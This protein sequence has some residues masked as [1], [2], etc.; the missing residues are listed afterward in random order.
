MI[1]LIVILF[2]GRYLN[3]FLKKPDLN[4]LTL[5]VKYLEHLISKNPQFE[6]FETLIYDYTILGKPLEALKLLKQLEK[7]YPTKVDSVDYLLFKY[8]ILMNIYFSVKENSLKKQIKN[9]IKQILF[10]LLTK[11]GNSKKI[12]SFVYFQSIEFGFIDIAYQAAYKLAILTKS[13]VW[14]KKAILLAINVKYVPKQNIITLINLVNL[15]EFDLKT[16]EK[17]IK[18]FFYVK[19][20]YKESYKFLQIYLK[21]SNFLPEDLQTIYLYLAVYNNKILDI[22]EIIEETLKKK[23]KKMLIKLA[24]QYALAMKKLDLAKKLIDE[25]ALAFP[26]DYAYIT[27][28]IKSALATGDPFFARKISLKIMRGLKNE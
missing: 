11:A 7:K 16:L 28:I 25:Y 27:F 13:P 20:N 15:Q 12:L 24:I 8:K 10:T 21:K 18:F 23:D 3:S 2:P 6:Y 22:Q 9:N 19:R 26:N 14:V 5:Q 17:I 4:S 1:A